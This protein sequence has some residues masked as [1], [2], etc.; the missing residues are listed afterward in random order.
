MRKRGEKERARL[1]LI[2][3]K[4]ISLSSPRTEHALL[5]PIDSLIKETTQ[6]S[7]ALLPHRASSC[8]CLVDSLLGSHFARDRESLGSLE[9]TV[10]VEVAAV[11]EGEEGRAK[12]GK[13]TEESGKRGK[14]MKAAESEK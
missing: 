13:K 12:R 14:R 9:S 2:T 1:E 3:I 10:G 11:R 8:I 6:R 5:T 4:K 7:L